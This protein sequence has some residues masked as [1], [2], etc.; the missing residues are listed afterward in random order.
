MHGPT[1]Q[2][3]MNGKVMSTAP[4]CQ[5]EQIG[6]DARCTIPFRRTFQ[7]HVRR[8]DRPV[9]RLLGENGVSPTSPGIHYPRQDTTRLQTYE[10]RDLI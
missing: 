6:I 7:I 2:K 1:H 5:I 10:H 8:L 9:L 3:Q 4:G